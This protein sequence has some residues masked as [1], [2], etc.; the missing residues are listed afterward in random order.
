MDR[1]GRPSEKGDPR[2]RH[3]WRLRPPLVRTAAF[4]TWV[5]TWVVA[6]PAPAAE[7][8]F[9]APVPSIHPAN[10][11]VILPWARDIERQ[12]SGRVKLRF[13][14]WDAAPSH[15]MYDLV[16]RGYADGGYHSVR[17]LARYAPLAQIV[18]LPLINR[19][20]EAAA[21]ALWRT[22]TTKFAEA[23]QYDGVQ[24]L[25]FFCGPGSDLVSF[26]E[27]ITSIEA[28]Q[29]LRFASATPGSTAALSWLGVSVGAISQGRLH[30]LPATES[31]DALAGVSVGG[32]VHARLTQSVRSVTVVP[33]KV[34]M[35][36]F[37]VFLNAETWRKMPER[38]R[39][40]VRAASG[41]NLARRSRAW[42]RSD[43]E[44]ARRLPAG[45]QIAA[46][47][48]AFVNQLTRA[49]Q[50]LYD[51]WIA[52][53]NRLGVDGKAALA[54]YAAQADT[55]AVEEKGPPPPDPGRPV[56]RR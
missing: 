52:E 7:Y 30:E 34:S 1:V 29:R 14:E 20:A 51:E 6:L 48:P 53:A 37:V 28:L 23:A 44:F 27:P 11:T 4:A 47:P 56:R 32:L 22:Q 12:T 17:A 54:F 19:S 45:K 13:P 21:V 2:P 25:G 39:A 5:V 42:D 26:R 10:Q 3:G 9:E 8:A 38:D 41:E 36:A 55:P 31:F 46:A 50:P 49:W 35:P 40:V 33:G 16:R 43:E 15:Q 24:L 18:T